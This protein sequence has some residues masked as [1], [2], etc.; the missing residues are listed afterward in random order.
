VKVFSV[1]L[2]ALSLLSTPVMADEY[3]IDKKGMHASIQFRIMHLGYSWLWGRFND[4]DGE[5]SYDKNNISASKINVTINTSSIDT[6]HAERDKHLRAEEFL[7]VEQFPQSSFVSTSL[8]MK[9]NG[10][11]ELNGDFTLRGV[12]KPIT[13]YMSYLGEGNDPWGGYRAGFEGTTELVLA[14][15]GILKDL[16]PASKK[17]DLFL[18]IEGIKK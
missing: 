4:F 12:T 15:Y 3:V 5:F 8:T 18:S 11:I 13:I 17:L 16:G 9:D 10:S 7:D 6:N 1:A 2:L 14:D